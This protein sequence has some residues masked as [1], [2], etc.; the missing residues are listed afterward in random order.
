M[1]VTV[2]AILFFVMILVAGNLA[3]WAYKSQQEAL[4]QELSRRIG[5]VASSDKADIF[6]LQVK[7]QLVEALGNYGKQLDNLLKQSGAQF[8]VTGLVQRM[9]AAGIV[10]VV[11][12]FVVFRSVAALVG[13]GA[14]FLPLMYLNWVAGRRARAISAQLP[15]ALDLIGRSLQAGHGLSD[16]MRLCAEEMS[17]PVAAEFGRIYE[18]H[19]LGK[20]LR[21]CLE[22]ACARN[23]ANFDL[24]IFVSSV[25]LQRETGG[26]LIEIITNIAK[27]IRDRFMFMNKVRAMTSEAKFSALILGGLPFAVAGMISFVNPEYLKPLA[28]DPMGRFILYGAGT[29]Y[30]SGALLMR[31][32]SQIEV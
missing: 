24:K 11:V 13:L 6:E 21:D 28:L 3:Y 22:E 9:V 17:M 31:K 12:S 26:N 18:Q 16:S 23:P 2:I 25:L 19:N 15:D 14:A 27:T 10:G 7:D 5:T 29:L 1:V 20:D 32:V 8:T 30:G 4:D